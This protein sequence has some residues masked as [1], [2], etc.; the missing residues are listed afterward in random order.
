MAVN[1]ESTVLVVVQTARTRQPLAMLAN[2]LVLWLSITQTS[3]HFQLLREL[4]LYTHMQSL[5]DI[6]GLEVQR[7]PLRERYQMIA[8]FNV[9][10]LYWLNNSGK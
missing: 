4:D 8:K 9:M 10:N 6:R 5:A 7:H 3:T 1:L 2:P